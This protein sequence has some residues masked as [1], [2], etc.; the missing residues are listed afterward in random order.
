MSSDLCVN[1]LFLHCR[2]LGLALHAGTQL[3]RTRAC[4]LRWTRPKVDAVRGDNSKRG[5][6][7]DPDAL[8]TTLRSA[9]FDRYVNF[10]LEVEGSQQIA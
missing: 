8:T 9:M 3:A 5:A 4:A 1:R 10:A 7:F 2:F 6:T